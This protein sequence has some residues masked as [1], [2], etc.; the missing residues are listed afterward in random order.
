MNNE[1][2]NEINSILA[3]MITDELSNAQSYES[4][5]VEETLPKKIRDIISNMARDNMK[6]VG[7]LQ[8]LMQEY[9]ESAG[10]IELGISKAKDNKKADDIYP[11]LNESSLCR[12]R[13]SRYLK[14]KDETDMGN[15]ITKD[16]K[17]E[18]IVTQEDVDG[19]VVST[20]TGS[21]LG[22]IQ[23]RVD[24]LIGNKEAL[25]SKGVT[26]ISV[27]DGDGNDVY[28]AMQDEGTLDSNGNDSYDGDWVIYLD[29]IG[30]VSPYAD[31][32]LAGNDLSSLVYNELVQ[33]DGA[34]LT[35]IRKLDVPDSERYSADEV[36]PHAEGYIVKAQDFVLANAVA[37][38]YN[39]LIRPTKD[40]LI[41]QIPQEDE[42]E[43]F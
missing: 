1:K 37:A 31:P 17:K 7:I 23:K 11:N 42:K 27:K 20:Y 34:G 6:R 30:N 28:L 43:D 15:V 36:F 39:L 5:A 3:G 25:A 21:S 9:S 41:I 35:N 24:K 32:A 12:A 29:N 38:T 8:G 4:Y 22:R 19:N 2:K 18:F 40:G 16:K 33:D 14:E 26:V 13:A 10:D